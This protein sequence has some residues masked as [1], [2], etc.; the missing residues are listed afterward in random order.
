M[1]YT[2]TS[3]KYDRF[4]TYRSDRFAAIPQDFILVPGSLKT[5]TQTKTGDYL[6]NWKTIIRNGGDATTTFSGTKQ[7]CTA[8]PGSAKIYFFHNPGGGK[9]R[10]VEFQLWGGYTTNPS[11]QTFYTG[12]DET[13]ATN[14]ALIRLYQDIRSNQTHFSGMT[15]LGEMREAI[16]MIRRPA[17]ALRKGLGDYFSTLRKRKGRAP[18]HRLRSILS[19]TWLEYSF[20]WMPL[21]ND[22]KAAAEALARFEDDKRRTTARGYGIHETATNTQNVALSA[23][24][25]MYY[26][27]NVRDYAKCEVIY[28][29]GLSFAGSAP[30]GSARRLAELSGFTLSEFVPTAWELVP[31]SFLV[32]YFS[33]VG[34]ILT[35]IT[36]DTTNV[37]RITKTVRRTAGRHVYHQINDKRVREVLGTAYIETLGGDLGSHHSSMTAVNRTRPSSIG[38]PTLAFRFPPLESAKWINMAALTKL[39]LSLTPFR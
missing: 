33:N 27:S 11:P 36:T 32:D 18:K 6:P 10:T 14:Q 20:G 28:K 31:W 12:A 9:P 17:Q 19:D 39:G 37:F 24:N 3:S 38:Y 25:Y 13:K 16:S 15:F 7:E 5:F 23:T 2:K 26:D 29:V 30:F 21:I 35:A 4:D 34:D 22:V 1:P 8:R